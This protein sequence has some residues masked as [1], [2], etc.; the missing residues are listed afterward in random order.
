MA[1]RTTKRPLV[2]SVIRDETQAGYAHLAVRVP[3]PGREV[4]AKFDSTKSSREPPSELSVQSFHLGGT[5]SVTR[6]PSSPTPV[7]M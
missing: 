4:T 6:R 5:K 2:F 3:E 7:T 1:S